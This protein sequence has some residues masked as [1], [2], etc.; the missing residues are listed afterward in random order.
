MRGAGGPGGQGERWKGRVDLGRESLIGGGTSG[1]GEAPLRRGLSNCGVSGM[2]GKE[3]WI[4]GS[5][6]GFRSGYGTGCLNPVVAYVCFGKVGRPRPTP[7]PPLRLGNHPHPVIG[8]LLSWIWVGLLFFQLHEA[9]IQSLLPRCAARGGRHAA[10]GGG[11]WS[12]G[13]NES[14]MDGPGGGRRVGRDELVRIRIKDSLP[15]TVPALF[16]LVLN[17]YLCFWA[18]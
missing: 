6:P 14:A 8:L 17:T 4:S 9:G 18:F 2:D 15:Q 3:R 13:G 1:G 16:Y 12:F 7:L 11:A 10:S 5:S